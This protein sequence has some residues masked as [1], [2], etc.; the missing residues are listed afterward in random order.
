MS[1]PE[2]SRPERIDTI[3]AGARTIEVKADAAERAALAERFE[4]VSIGRLTA[5]FAVRRDASGIV[6]EGRVQAEVVQA[7][8]V[9]GEL[10]PVTVDEPVALLF[11]AEA[12]TGEEEIE[13]TPDAL[14]VIP[15]HGSSID[16][17]EAAAETMVLALDPFPRS[18]SAE[19]VLREA[20]VLREEETGR[21]SGLAGLKDLLQTKQE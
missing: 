14:D 10:L 1:T 7:C 20:G 19:A 18:P 9:T 13:L 17:G 8:V 4:L 2:F 5:Q 15:F 21:L 16:L 11:V 6:A 3:G 12:E